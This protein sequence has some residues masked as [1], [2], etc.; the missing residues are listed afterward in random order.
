MIILKLFCCF[1]LFYF[2]VFLTYVY[3]IIIDILSHKF[4]LT[5]QREDSIKM[6]PLFSVLL[7]YIHLSNVQNKYYLS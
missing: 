6:N 7:T 3:I 5:I 4:S 2:V 1:I